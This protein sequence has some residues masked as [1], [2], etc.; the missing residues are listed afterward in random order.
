MPTTIRSTGLHMCSIC[1]RIGAFIAPYF[2]KACNDYSYYLLNSLCLVLCGGAI[3][4]TLGLPETKDKNLRANLGE[5]EEGEDD[6][7]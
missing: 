6:K 4:L 3:V 1:A 7:L 2:V 5:K